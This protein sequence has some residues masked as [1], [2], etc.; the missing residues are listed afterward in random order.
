MEKAEK[1]AEELQEMRKI[2]GNLKLC[3]GN[4]SLPGLPMNHLGDHPPCDARNS[5]EG[6]VDVAK[7]QVGMCQIGNMADLYIILA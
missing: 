1:A 4:W 6:H 7:A 2:P 5:C 3:H